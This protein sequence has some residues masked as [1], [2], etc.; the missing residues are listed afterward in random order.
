MTPRAKT[1][2]TTEYTT[3]S[4]EVSSCLTTEVYEDDSE[5]DWLVYPVE[6]YPGADYDDGTPG[7]NSWGGDEE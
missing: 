2:V 5:L 1:T 6:L 3:E 7:E 4:V